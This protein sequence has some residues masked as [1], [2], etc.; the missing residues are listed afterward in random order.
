MT[1]P[2]LYLTSEPW[3]PFPLGGLFFAPAFTRERMSAGHLPQSSSASRFTAGASEFFILS[4]SGERLEPRELPAVTGLDRLAPRYRR[5][6]CRPPSFA[7]ARRSH[8]FDYTPSRDA[9][10]AAPIAVGDSPKGT[11]AECATR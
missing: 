9:G 1:A 10:S 8:R 3:P 6:I 2:S 11:L 4:Q 5:G 7:W